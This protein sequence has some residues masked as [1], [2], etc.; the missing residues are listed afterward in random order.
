MDGRV[1]RT[2]DGNAICAP[3]SAANCPPASPCSH[4]KAPVVSTLV[5][6]WERWF[7]QQNK[8]GALL[9]SEKEVRFSELKD[10]Q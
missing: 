3:V 7:T 5:L 10:A 4:L 9:F 8:R 2:P 6:A 1:R